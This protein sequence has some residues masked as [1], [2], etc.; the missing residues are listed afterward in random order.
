VEGANRK[1]NISI[2]SFLGSP[3]LFFMVHMELYMVGWLWLF[4]CLASHQPCFVTAAWNIGTGGTGRRLS[5]RS[6]RIGVVFA[7]LM[8]I[9]DEQNRNPGLTR[10]ER[11]MKASVVF[12]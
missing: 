2:A 8:D 7:H 6:A 5:G 10:R 4:V 11:D 12:E 1:D 3:G 9:A